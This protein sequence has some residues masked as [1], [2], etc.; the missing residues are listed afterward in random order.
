MEKVDL[1]SVIIPCYNCERF[2]YD[3]LLSVVE[4]TYN[5]L[6][7]IVID[8]GSTDKSAEIIH[9]FKDTRIRYYYQKNKGHFNAR[10]KGMELSKGEYIA[11]LDSD[12]IWYN[13]KLEKQYELLIKYDIVYCDYITI[14]EDNQIIKF[15]NNNPFV[16]KSNMDNLKKSL[17]MGNIVLGSLSAVVLKKEV[18]NKVGGF[19]NYI[20]GEDWELWAR[21]AWNDYLFGFVD[22]KLV[23]IRERNESVVKT[24]KEQDQKDSIEKILN[25]FLNFPNITNKERSI[26][27]NTH[28]RNCYQY[29]SNL[30]EMIG[31]MFKTIQLDYKNIFKINYLSIPKFI[32]KKL[33]FSILKPSFEKIVVKRY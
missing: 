31:Y 15:D 8:D 21:I 28:A 12:D 13:N 11:F 7:I 1:I 30:Y 14:N 27:Y 9:S 18:I 2:I 22:E 32:L 29:L 23:K 19:R 16:D 17:L 5:N 4:Q 6:E 33:F 10:N 3:T 26:I 24:T 20:V 25:S